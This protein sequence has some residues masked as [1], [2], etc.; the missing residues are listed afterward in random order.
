M[1]FKNIM[2]LLRLVKK[3]ADSSVVVKC[4]NDICNVLAH[5]NL[6]IPISCKKLR[7]SVNEVGGE[8]LV[9]YT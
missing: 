9:D 5:I 6:S 7:S 1:L 3:M 4:I 8:D 2:Y